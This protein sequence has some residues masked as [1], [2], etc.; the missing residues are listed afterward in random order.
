MEIIGVRGR[1]ILLLEASR[2][3]IAKLIGYYYAHEDACPKLEP[4]MQ[5]TIS[6]MYSQLYRLARAQKEIETAS[7]TL[8]SVAN[9]VLIMDPLIDKVLKEGEES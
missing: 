3:E 2:D 9:L 1:E 8:H 5:I 6:D 7:K 4:G